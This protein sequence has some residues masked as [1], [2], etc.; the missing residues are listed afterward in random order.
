MLWTICVRDWWYFEQEWCVERWGN[1][2]VGTVL[3]FSHTPADVICLE[4][5]DMLRHLV[6]WVLQH[7]VGL[8]CSPQCCIPAPLQHPAASCVPHH[9]FSAVPTIY[10][11]SASLQQ[12]M[13]WGASTFVQGERKER[14]RCFQLSA[15]AGQCH[16]CMAQRRRAGE[17]P[18]GLVDA[19][20][21]TTLILYIIWDHNFSIG[22]CK[23]LEMLVYVICHYSGIRTS[24]NCV[25]VQ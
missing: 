22:H 6:W 20:H 24:P 3:A 7:E 25:R 4:N 8:D 1:A 5:Q 21:N 16:H 9:K 13:R 15:G 19:E 18:P 2:L 14:T 12:F 17:G 10:F 23:Q 11:C